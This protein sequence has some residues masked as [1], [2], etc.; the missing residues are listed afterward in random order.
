MMAKRDVLLPELIPFTK[1]WHTKP[2]PF[3]SP[4]RPELS[5][6]GKNV[7]VTG[8]GTGIG[9]AIAV[10]FTQAGAASV[11]ILGRRV[12]RL[13][14]ASAEI[15]ASGPATR[16]LYE[17]ADLTQR[18]AVDGALQ[19]VVHRVGK[20]DIFVSNA[21][22]LPDMAPSIGYN[23]SEF[24]R[25]FELNVVST[26]NAVQGFIPLAAPDAMLF[27]IS[28]AAA[29]F[30]PIPG[31][32]AYAAGKAASLKMLYYVA[33]ENPDLH[34]VHVQPGAVAT[35]MN[36]GR[37]IETLDQRRLF[38]ASGLALFVGLA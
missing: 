10:A 26:F 4:T 21:G 34:V 7:V 13:Q 17:A 25:S 35:E 22:V 18:T 15:R 8:G 32:F 5:A 29:H 38:S 28:S 37:G 2:Y 31:A 9:K 23:L 11:A 19:S 6:A 24:R 3:I 20:I 16:V 36:A 33:A 1:I 30:A 27:N 14:A 12:D